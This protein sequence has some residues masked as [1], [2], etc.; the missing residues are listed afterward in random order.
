[1]KTI[2]LKLD[3]VVSWHG[4]ILWMIYKGPLLRIHLI[5]MHIRVWILDQDTDT[6]TDPG[7]QHFFKFHQFF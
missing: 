6:D 1:M 3:I 5:L 7:H 2:E 4:I